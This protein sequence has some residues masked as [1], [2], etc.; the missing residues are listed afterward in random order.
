MFARPLTLC[1]ALALVAALATSALASCLADP[2]MSA[3]SE[4][5]CCRVGHDG[6]PMPGSATDCCKADSQKQQPPAVAKAES[7][8]STWTAPALVAT[9]IVGSIDSIAPM[10]A[11]RIL[12]DTRLRPPSTPDHFLASALLL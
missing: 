4:M 12:R 11:I 2:S 7:I 10:R 1:L 6:C 8:R 5:A 3:G 9:A